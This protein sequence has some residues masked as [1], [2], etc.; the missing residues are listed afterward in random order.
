M[1]TKFLCTTTSIDWRH[2][3]K[4]FK[5]LVATW[6]CLVNDDWTGLF[7]FI[8]KFADVISFRDAK[9]HCT[10]ILS[11]DHYFCISV[12]NIFKTVWGE[13]YRSASRLVSHS[14]R[15]HW[16]FI[17][18]QPRFSQCKIKKMKNAKLIMKA[19]NFSILFLSIEF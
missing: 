17:L 7:F 12:L 6:F 3:W 2:R 5:M 10:Y 8:Y 19:N 14:I 18:A 16:N 4:I 15:F 13:D 9:G 11:I 1:L